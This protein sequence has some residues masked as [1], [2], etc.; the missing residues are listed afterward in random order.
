MKYYIPKLALILF[1]FMVSCGPGKTQKSKD[2]SKG[3]TLSIFDK[4]W[5]LDQINGQNIQYA[6]EQ[7]KW[8][9]LTL[10]KDDGGAFGFAG[11]NNFMGKFET[12]ADDA[13]Q[14]SKMASTRMACPDRSFNEHEYLSNLDKVRSYSIDEETLTLNNEKGKNILTFSYRPSETTGIVEKY[15]KL[16][17]LNGKG[18]TMGKNQEKEV[19]FMLKTAENRVQGF[20]GCNGFGGTYT[21]VDDHKIEFSQM[22]GTLKACP[23]VDFNEAEFLKLFREVDRYDLQGDQLQFL[24][25]DGQDLASFEAVYF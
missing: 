1:G 20:S 18:V 22:I 7:G 9:S 25:Q 8:P 13:L 21:L 23:D 11:C 10:S 12:G 4:E 6:N 3:D 24:D 19:H 17:K 5:H 14:F 2:L 15:W 16:T